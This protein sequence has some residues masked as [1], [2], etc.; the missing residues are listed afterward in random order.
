MSSTLGVAATAAVLQQMLQ[1]G[2]SA[3]KIGDVLGGTPPSVTCL[4]ADRVDLEGTASLINLFLYYL[5]RN[6]GWSNLDYPSR[7]SRGERVANPLL[8]L[9]LYFMVTAYGV[10]DFHAEVLLGAAMQILHETPVLGRESIRLALK[11]DPAKPNIPKQLELAGLAD[12]LE[13]VRISPVNQSIDDVSRIWSAIQMPLRQSAAYMVSVVLIDTEPSQRVPLPVLGSRIY[14]MPFKQPRI[15]RVEA[16]D[17]PLSPILVDTILCLTG[18]H[19]KAQPMRVLVSG[20]DVTSGLSKVEDQFLELSLLPAI[21][22]GLR[23]GVNTVQVAHP[24][25]MGE[26]QTEHSAVES[27]LAAFVLNPKAVFS[28]ESG[29][30]STVINGVTYKTGKIKVTLSPRVDAHQRVR[31]LLN[32]QNPPN[33]RPAR[34]Y[35]FYAGERNGITPPATDTDIILIPYM[36]VAQGDFLARVQVDAGISPLTTGVD[37]RFASPVVTL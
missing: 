31:L 4:P 1:N 2:L 35:T 22:K 6:S 29:A 33:T 17:A 30:T 12:Q 14:V 8:A 34:A 16:A 37:G 28:V 19:F 13:Q 18:A 24:Q 3:L 7:D 20:L 10:A 27:N 32:E 25:L 36:L 11:P 15:D 9:D 23:S 21:P 5:T 26:P